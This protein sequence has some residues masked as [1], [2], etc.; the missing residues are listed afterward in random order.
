LPNT[1][2]P[3]HSIA[4]LW[5][6]ALPHRLRLQKALYSLAE[7][8][9][10]EGWNYADLADLLP[11]NPLVGAA[12]LVGLITRSSGVQVLF[13]RRTETL[14]HHAGQVGFPGGRIEHEDSSPLAAAL[15][16][17]REEIGLQANQVHP[18]G[19]LDPFVVISGY[20]VLPVVAAIDP[21]FVAAPCPDEV[22][23]V[24][25][26]PLDFLLN[27]ANVRQL[28]FHHGG[29]I[30]YVPEYSWPEQRIWGASAAILCNL[31]QRLEQAT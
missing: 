17:S 19:Y 21:N 7:A 18:L 16:E 6:P 31:R 4:P 29:K 22:A 27:P 3:I 28:A 5:L 9:S 8:P 26:V 25:E 12:V 14:R 2:Y 24:F 23:E 15:R 10:G 20:R 30:R 11:A 13:T 1:H